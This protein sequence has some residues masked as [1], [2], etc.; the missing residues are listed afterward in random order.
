MIGK[1]CHFQF[2]PFF[3]RCMQS[4]MNTR[5]D[6]Y[7]L[8]WWRWSK[9]VPTSIVCDHPEFVRSPI[10]IIVREWVWCEI[11]EPSPSLESLLNKSN[12]LWFGLFTLLHWDRSST[13]TPCKDKGHH[14]DVKL[15]VS[16]CRPFIIGWANG[17]YYCHPHKGQ[18][19][20]VGL[21][22]LPLG[23]VLG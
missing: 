21:L 19:L 12:C 9:A 7:E 16:V 11:L 8:S 2:G 6:F 17:N 18:R 22:T 10:H 15:R 23:N 13:K 14:S 1:L 20:F 3:Q 4:K 5:V